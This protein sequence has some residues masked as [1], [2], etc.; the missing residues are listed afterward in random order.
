MQGVFYKLVDDALWWS[1]PGS[2][3]II[4]GSTGKMESVYYPCELTLT[5]FLK[6]VQVLSQDQLFLIGGN[7]A[8][9]EMRRKAR[10]PPP[11]SPKPR[12]VKDGGNRK[13]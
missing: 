10:P 4:L 6:E 13:Q 9:N 3:K 1:L 5:Q 8:L 12:I 2:G 11:P 7:N